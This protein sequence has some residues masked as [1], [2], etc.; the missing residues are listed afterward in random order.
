MDRTAP[1]LLLNADICA[2]I[3]TGN[4][5]PRPYVWTKTADQILESIAATALA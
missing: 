3:A 1:L 2:W 5:D 4:D